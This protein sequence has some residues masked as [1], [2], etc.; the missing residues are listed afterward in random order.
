[1]ASKI[2][3]MPFHTVAVSV[4]V[5]VVIMALHLQGLEAQQ[6]PLVKGL[7]WKYYESSCPKLESIIRKQMEKVI[8]KDVGLA[9]ALLRLHF[10][11]CFVQV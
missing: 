5:L 9:A 11:D 6:Q 7:S 4:G 3:V 1:M 8:K 10:H 2:T